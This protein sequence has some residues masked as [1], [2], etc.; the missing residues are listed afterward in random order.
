MIGVLEFSTIWLNA[1][2]AQP[3]SRSCRSSRAFRGRPCRFLAAA[4]FKA[5]I[6]TAICFERRKPRA[7]AR[8]TIDSSGETEARPVPWRV[9][10]G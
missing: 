10:V 5:L 8:A 7:R 3:I 9:H 6:G 1:R 4:S 2:R